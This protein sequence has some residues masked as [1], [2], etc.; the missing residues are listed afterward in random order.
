[1]LYFPAAHSGTHDLL[2]WSEPLLIGSQSDLARAI[3]AGA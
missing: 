1:M 3:H 2:H